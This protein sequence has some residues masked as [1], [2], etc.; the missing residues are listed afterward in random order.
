MG[1]IKSS[2]LINGDWVFQERSTI[3]KDWVY[4]GLSILSSTTHLIQG[5]FRVCQE[6]HVVVDKV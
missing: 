4:D 1:E 3:Y 2:V 6:I 5:F